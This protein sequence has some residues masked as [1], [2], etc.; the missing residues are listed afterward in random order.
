MPNSAY[1]VIDIIGSSDTSWEK[2]LQNAVDTA[3]ESIKHPR[4]AEIKEQDAT[5]DEQGRI[6]AYR[7]RV[8]LSFKYDR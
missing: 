5:I 7:V 3:A 2:A 6:T 4:V 1:K 8:S